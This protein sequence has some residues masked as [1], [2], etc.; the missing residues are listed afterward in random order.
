MDVSCNFFL[1]SQYSPPIYLS[2]WGPKLC[3]IALWY[4]CSNDQHWRKYFHLKCVKGHMLL[5]KW[6]VSM[7]Y[8][9]LFCLGLP[10]SLPF[11]V[12]CLPVQLQKRFFTEYY[13]DINCLKWRKS[14]VVRCVLEQ[15][16]YFSNL[17]SGSRVWRKNGKCERRFL[18]H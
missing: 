4:I 8:N 13:F 15:K 1:S 9:F 10:F 3:D 18:S 6:H 17:H 12:Q 5:T 2:S 16:W 14:P 7:A 11:A